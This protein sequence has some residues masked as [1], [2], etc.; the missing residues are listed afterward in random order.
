MVPAPSAAAIRRIET[1]SK[2]SASA[3]ATAAAAIWP[4]LNRDC[5]V[6]GSGRVQRSAAPDSVIA[7]T[8]S[9]YVVLSRRSVYSHLVCRRHPVRLLVR[10]SDHEIYLVVGAEEIYRVA[11]A[12]ERTDAEDD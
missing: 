1:A 5:R 3:M 9:A 11:R 2:P 6:P 4:R 12:E 7:L 8:S 10:L